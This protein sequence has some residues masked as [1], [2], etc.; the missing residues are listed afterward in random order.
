MAKWY[1]LHNHFGI[2][3]KGN[4]DSIINFIICF[5]HLKRA[6]LVRI[7]LNK[8]AAATMQNINEFLLFGDKTSL[9]YSSLVLLLALARVGKF[10]NFV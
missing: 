2:C 8:P 4:D 3:N 9:Y 6:R 1:I 10:A 7:S 5:S